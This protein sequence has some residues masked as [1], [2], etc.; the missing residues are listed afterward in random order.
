MKMFKPD[1]SVLILISLFLCGSRVAGQTVV[2][3]A[4]PSHVVNKFS[5]LRALG[6]TVDRVPTNATDVFFRPDQ[7]QKVLSAG[8]GI[9]SY[10]Q[11]TDLFVQAWHWNPKGAWSDPAGKGYFTGDATP[12]NEMIRHSY[13]YSLPH[14]G[15]TR[16][17]GSEFDGYS[18][19]DDG[20][21]DSYWK[22][23]PYLAS[24]FTGES[25]SLHPQWVVIALDKKESVNAIRILWGA[26]FAREFQ[27]QYWI[28]DGDAM[29]EQDKGAW[30]DFPSGT[31]T[32]GKGS[33]STMALSSTPVTTKFVRIWMTAS[34]HTCDTHGSSDRRNC[35]G[36]AIKEVYLGTLAA[37]GEFKDLLHHSPDQKQTLTLCSSVDPW[38]EPSDLYVAP[39]RMESGDQPG[40]DLFFT[41][42]IT[43][44]LPAIVPVALLY[45]TP[46][47]A[48]AQMS[49]IK[50][51][52]YPVSYIEMGE[53]ADGQY[54]LPEDYGAL[55]LQFAT[56]LHRVDPAFKL[57]GPSFQGVTE[58]IK[59]WPDAHGR[60]SWFGR[61]LAYLNDHHRLQDFSFMS[62]EHYP[63]DG[64]DTP[65]ENIYQ[66]P[67]LI[68]HIM[69]VW[70]DDGLPPGIPLLD[71]ETNAH[72]GEASVDIFGALWL[73]DSFAGFLTAGGQSTH[74]YHDL[75]YSPP[76][77][78]CPNSWGTYHLFMADDHYQIVQP[79]SQFFAAQLL[80]QEWTQPG[81]A[82]HL[83]Y[84][85][86]SDLKDAQGHVLVTAYAVHRPDD[87]WSLLLVNRDHD[88]PHPVRITFRNST[89]NQDTSFAGQVTVITFGKE[90]YQWHPARKQGRADPDG[91]P[92][93]SNVQGGPSAL[94]NLPAASVTVVRGKLAAGGS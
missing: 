24:D 18:R 85:A 43:R 23:N 14:R 47:D 90:Q 8:W 75:S 38:H 65:W 34:S 21:T 88:H 82:E 45:S 70:R 39:D 59:A 35:V 69:Q 77:P 1:F 55:Y 67:E 76:H 87:Q 72:G 78:A 22:S 13:G 17:G 74:Y 94:Y 53:E 79:T 19:L 6:S 81:D 86:T 52:G 83:L 4:T 57:G 68:T 3:D 20:D 48:A 63:Y 50:K 84:R 25:D 64:C 89:S 56:A 46:D 61:F 32:T 93:T 92:V 37:N 73:A 29:D 30:K 9:I 49:Y 51:R 15:F 41:S 16:N 42:G 2:V 7:I 60:T 12:T 27:V 10:R 54:M 80:T 11:N 28:G 44:G 36:Y 5:P 33:D 40:F 31:V 71:T 26:P 58:D 91:P 62:F 66:E